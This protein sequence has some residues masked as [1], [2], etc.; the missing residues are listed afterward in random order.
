[1]G[2]YLLAALAVAGCQFDPSGTAGPGDDGDDAPIDPD[3]NTVV[4][5]GDPGAIDA[6]PIDAADVDAMPAAACSSWTYTP[7]NVVCSGSPGPTL[8]ITGMAT[9]DTDD[10]S[11][12]GGGAPPSAV[13]AQF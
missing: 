9:Y 11:L 13:V 7:A 5:D 4:I 1:M 8:V 3:A 10:G 2:K 12:S 6:E